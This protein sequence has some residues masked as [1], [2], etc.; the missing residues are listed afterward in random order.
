M[1]PKLKILFKRSIWYIKTIKNWPTIFFLKLIRKTPTNIIFRN[2]LII[3]NEKTNCG[4]LSIIYEIF[5]EEI[6]FKN[7]IT[8]SHSDII[9]DIGANIGIF[10]LFVG[11]KSNNKI[12]AIEPSTSTFKILQQNMEKN[13]MKTV[14]L[15]N[16]AICN[17][18]NNKIKLFIN[19]MH[20]GENSI[21]PNIKTNHYEL[22]ETISL[23]KIIHDYEIPRIDILKVDCEGCEYDLFFNLSHKIFALI[24]QIT[25][26]FHIFDQEQKLRK[27]ITILKQNSFI[28][29]YQLNNDKKSGYLWAINR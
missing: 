27:L 23:E 21:F 4:I 8:K 5:G 13:N 3:S 29:K 26:E 16:K 24:R 25:M 6:Y 20:W 28:V 2:G 18:T 9:V 1:M 12:F 15:I 14:I 22:V 10:T 17:I 11:Y 19:D 7:L